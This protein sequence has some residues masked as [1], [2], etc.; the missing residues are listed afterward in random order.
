MQKFFFEEKSVS[1][2]LIGLVYILVERY[3]ETRSS[4]RKVHPEESSRDLKMENN[5]NICQKKI[6][7]SKNE[8]VL[9][10]RSGDSAQISPRPLPRSRSDA[11]VT[12]LDHKTSAKQNG[13]HWTKRHDFPLR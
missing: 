3:E 2:G 7:D 9:T 11:D 13:I 8:K 4:V 5:I 6:H 1:A 12:P 10:K